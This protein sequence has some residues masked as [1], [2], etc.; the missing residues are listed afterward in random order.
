MAGEIRA[1]P[2]EVTRY[3][4][5]HLVGKGFPPALME[6]AP[7]PDKAGGTRKV[8]RNGFVKVVITYE[9][10]RNVAVD[11]VATELRDARTE[12]TKTAVGWEGHPAFVAGD[13]D[14]TVRAELPGEAQVTVW[15]YAETE[16][17]ATCSFTVKE[18]S[19]G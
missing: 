17:L 9:W 8:V 4:E 10:I 16:Q 1:L 6:E 11:G 2:D 14:L 3:E 18:P 13:I 19:D 15:N 5:V 7:D 12:V